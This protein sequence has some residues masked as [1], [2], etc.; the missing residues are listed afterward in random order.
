MTAPLTRPHPHGTLARYKQHCS[1]P[2]CR[3]ANADYMRRRRRM[4]AYGWWKGLA[5]PTGT[6]RRLQA[7]VYNGWSL[8]L[9]ST[10]LGRDRTNLRK[11]LY[12][13]KQVNAA[14]IRQVRALYDELWDQ[15]PPERDLFEKGAA[16]KARKYAR[17]RGW[18]PPLAWS[19]DEID[20]P[21]ASP[22]DWE[23]GAGREWGTLAAE[24]LDLLGFGLDSRQAAE[25]LGIS[26]ST[27][28][29]TL[30]RARKREEQDAA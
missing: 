15:P 17:E 9:L 8:G 6:R 26:Q 3:R 21:A 19:D 28:T 1:C 23:R 16:T 14:T 30:A 22:A 27:L 2:P 12:E 4:M 13:S 29:T 20:D 7:L 24:A 25:R 11:M 10:R 5:D 18:V